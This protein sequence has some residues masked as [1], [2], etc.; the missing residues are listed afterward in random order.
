MS[1]LRVAIAD[2]SAL[3]RQGVARVL[4][5]AGFEVVAQSENAV[6]LM[7]AIGSL[8]PDV[9]VIISDLAGFA[10]DDTRTKRALARLRRSAGSII[11]IV[12]SPQGF[13]PVATSAHGRRVR[14]LMVRDQQSTMEPGRRLLLRHGVRVIE[15]APGSSLD[16]LLHGRRNAA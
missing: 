3:M 13:L 15:G 12:P 9:A 1:A 11:A 4:E 7:H 6:D 8:K 16:Q 10:E 5:D 14:E 2:D